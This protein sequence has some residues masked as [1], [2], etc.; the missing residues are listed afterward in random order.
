[1]EVFVV[2]EDEQKIP[3]PM[4][5]YEMEDGRI[6]VVEVEGI[7]KEV[8]EKMEEEPAMEEE[9]TVEVEVEAET[10]KTAPKKTIE[11]VVKETFFTEIEALKTELASIKEA[12]E[13]ELSTEEIEPKKIEFNPE[14]KQEKSNFQF[15]S[16]K[17]ETIEDRIR[18]KLFN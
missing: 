10:A 3:V 11:S 16:N 15:G 8:K 6:L 2:T 12:K 1:M 5:E 4:G 13:V 7:I 9:P 14:N 18:R 17:M